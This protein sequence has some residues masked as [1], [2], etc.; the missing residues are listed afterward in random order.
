MH[1]SVTKIDDY[2]RKS[3]YLKSIL[4]ILLPPSRT[5]N[6]SKLKYHNMFYNIQTGG[7]WVFLNHQGGFTTPLG[8]VWPWGGVRPNF[9][10][11]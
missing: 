10:G 1:I 4:K 9:G 8:G 5:D 7:V 3:Y 11:W 6:H 2:N